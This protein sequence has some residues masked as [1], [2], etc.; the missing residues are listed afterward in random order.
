MTMFA[1]FAIINILLWLICLAAQLYAAWN[2]LLF[3]LEWWKGGN[4]RPN[5]RR[6]LIGLLV[7]FAILAFGIFQGRIV[8]LLGGD[9]ISRSNPAMESHERIIIRNANEAVEE[10][11]PSDN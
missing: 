11:Q 7:V 9:N 10:E 1:I 5:L 2:L 8:Q 4:W 3:A 6:S